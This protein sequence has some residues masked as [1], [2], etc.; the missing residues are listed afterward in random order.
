MAVGG[1][2]V[3]AID[4]GNNSLK[5][6]RLQQAG[7]RVEAIGL[8]YVEHSRVLSAEGLSE[9]EKNQII[10]ASL[11]TFA[12]RNE[13]GK[14]EVAISVAGQT[15]FARFIKLPPVEPKKVPEI[16]KFEAVQQIPFDINEVEW[17]WQLMPKP[18]SPE[19]EVGIFAIKNELISKHLENYSAENICVT[20]VQMAPMALYNYA[21]FDRSDLDSADK[22]AVVLLD[23]GSGD[24]N[25]VICTKSTVWQRCIPL[26]GNNFTKAIADAFKLD[27]EKAEKLK[28]S[29]PVSKY[30]RQIFHAMKP[31]FTDFGAEVQRSLG[32]Y[33]SSHKGTVFTKMILLG[34]GFKLQGLSKYIQQT[35]QLSAIRP[36]SFEKLVSAGGI[37]SAK[38]HDNLCDLAIAYGLGLQ[39]LGL[40][41]IQSNLL[42]RGIARRMLWA[43]KSK[44]FVLAASILLA[45]SL[46]ALLRTN[47][48]LK[49]SSDRNAQS[50][51]QE[52]QNILQLAKNAASQLKQQEARSSEYE[53]KIK[54]QMGM[55]K[56]RD[57]IP[58][59]HKIIF[60]CIP[61]AQNNPAQAELYKA[62]EESDVAK[63]AAIPRNERKQVFITSIMIDYYDSLA[64]AT[65]ELDR[66][67]RSITRTTSSADSLQGQATDGKGFTVIVEGYTPYEKIGELMDPAGVG[68]DK[69]RWGVITRMMN[70]NELFDGNSPF[71]LFSKGEI[72]HF[73][74]ETGVV[75]IADARMPAGIGILRIK[76]ESE[77]KGGGHAGQTNTSDIAASGQVLVDPLTEEEINKTVALDEKGRGK[78]DA[79]GQPVYIERDKWFRIRAKFLWENG[80]PDG[81]PLS[82]TPE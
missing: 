37:S 14:D 47:L 81:Q 82:G 19:T 9:E 68:N 63:I 35:T 76:P 20:V 38:L 33:S 79:F 74:V 40:A 75:D 64:A 15:S 72:E 4:I 2:S 59:L 3:W 67:E 30:V 70:L 60:K 27:F 50:K 49:A 22:K 55:F 44:F 11:A 28:H 18:D 41:R 43:R 42:P 69:S 46:L 54:K 61:D 65:F 80:K 32:Y 10:R 24:T 16:I 48:D 56:Y 39:A 34:G 6:L 17:D 58:L 51:R 31:V 73:R 5:A 71:Q 45:A 29:A 25:L 8:D 62:Y 12:G 78:Y 7:D 23:M 26:G 57:I 36:D 52:T 77:Y 21:Q 53:E 13:L 1:R 66:R